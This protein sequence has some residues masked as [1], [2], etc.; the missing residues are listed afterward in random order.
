MSYQWELDVDIFNSPSGHGNLRTA[1]HL[2]KVWN[3]DPLH[4]NAP[5]TLHGTWKVSVA[6]VNRMAER[7]YFVRF[8]KDD[9]NDKT[10][11]SL[12]VAKAYALAIITLEQ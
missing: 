9:H 12:K 8:A 2:K 4:S 1:W 11:R 6:W 7:K 5:V 10:F 3:K